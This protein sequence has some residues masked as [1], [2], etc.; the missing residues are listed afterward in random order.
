MG[1]S[2]PQWVLQFS[3]YNH[4]NPCRRCRVMACTSS[5]LKWLKIDEICATANFVA[6]SNNIV[7]HITGRMWVQIL[8]S[9]SL[10]RRFIFGFFPH[11]THLPAGNPITVSHAHTPASPYP[12]WTYGPWPCVFIGTS[13]RY[14]QPSPFQVYPH[15]ATLP[16]VG[17][18]PSS[19][20]SLIYYSPHFP[21]AICL[22]ASSPIFQRLSLLTNAL[23]PTHST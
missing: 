18:L 1:R 14:A 17:F 13:C 11:R 16:R 23:P 7:E 19:N 2:S 4:T 9:R 6:N 8:F 22:P 3:L 15:R 10:A 21:T 20:A 5:A 12:W